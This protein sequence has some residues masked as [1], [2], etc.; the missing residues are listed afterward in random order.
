[1]TKYTEYPIVDPA[2]KKMTW[3]EEEEIKQFKLGKKV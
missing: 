1:L 2:R 3:E